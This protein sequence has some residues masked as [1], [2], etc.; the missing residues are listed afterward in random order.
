MRADGA[1]VLHFPWAGLVAVSAGGQRADWTDVDAHAAFFT[2]Q[3]VAFIGSDHGTGAAELYAERRY[4]H[5]FTADAHA[6]VTKNAARTIKEDHGRPLL[7]FF[8]K[9][10]FHIARFRRT[11]FKSHVLQFAFAAGIADRAIQRMVAEKQFDHRLARLANFVGV[12]GH[13][14]AVSNRH[15]AGGLEL[16]HFFNAHQAHAAGGLKRKSRVV[17]E[18][19]DFNTHGLASL[20]QE[21]ARRRTDLL[22]V[23]SD[24]Y[25]FYFGH[26]YFKSNLFL[27]SSICAA[28]RFACMAIAVSISQMLTIPAAGCGCFTSLERRSSLYCSKNWITPARVVLNCSAASARVAKR[29]IG[30]ARSGDP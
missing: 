17:T 8:M 9:L 5:A 6:A 20:N 10:A 12:R 25:V 15:R 1:N 30:F 22:A 14:H 7:L 13:N 27:I 3:M 16:R 24:G 19:R 26:D 21:C 18:R 11:I 23:N 29:P 2:V 28:C 4:I